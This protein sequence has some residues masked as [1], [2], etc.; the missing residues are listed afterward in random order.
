MKSHRVARARLIA[1]AVTAAGAVLTA[2]APV[3]AGAAAIVGDHRIT[4]AELDK[5]VRGFE[6]AVTK[7]K[8]PPQGLQIAD[9]N[10]YP[11]SV[12]LNM[13]QVDLFEQIARRHKVSVTEGEVDAYVQSQGGPAAIEQK[14][15]AFGVP[16]SQTR[17]FLRGMLLNQKLNQAFG[18]GADEAAAQRAAARLGEEAGKIDLKIN[19]RYGHFDPQQGFVAVQRFTKPTDAQQAQGQG[20]PGQEMPPP[21]Q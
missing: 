21:G 10:S 9:P 5:A 18:G 16:P 2:C 8:I 14:A 17:S 7:A 12:L 4:S 3:Q 6:T 11:R 1:L 15:L 19:P 13:V 20:A